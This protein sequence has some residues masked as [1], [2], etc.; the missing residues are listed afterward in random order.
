MLVFALGLAVVAMG[1]SAQEAPFV[2]NGA[3]YDKASVMKLAE[4]VDT[5]KTCHYAEQ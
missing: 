2:D 5:A 3:A 1:C 4:G